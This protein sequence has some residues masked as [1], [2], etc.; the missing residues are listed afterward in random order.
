MKVTAPSLM[1]RGE[2]VAVF[3]GIFEHSPWVAETAF[4]AGLDEAADHP[5][6]L[7]AALCL[8]MRAVSRDQKLALIRAHPDLAGKLAIRGKLT[9]A[10]STEHKSAGLDRCTAD[11]FEKLTALNRVYTQ[12]FGF[13]FIMAVKGSTRHEIIAAMEA[14][15][16]NNPDNEF[17]TAL[18]QIERI[19]L[20]RL[21]DIFGEP[22]P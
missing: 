22:E 3:G 2:F 12:R 7:H 20:L 4:D 14:R 18:M 11:E 10:S 17:E 19:A 9:E 21:Q 13:P 15:A 1:T 16:S 8:A 6:G 5:S